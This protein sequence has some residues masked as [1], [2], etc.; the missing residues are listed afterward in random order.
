[1]SKKNNTTFNTNND[2]KMPFDI[3]RQ[4]A[5]VFGGDDP[6]RIADNVNLY[7]YVFENFTKQRDEFVKNLDI[8]I[9]V[10]S[11]GRLLRFVFGNS[12]LGVNIS[13]PIEKIDVKD[14]EAFLFSKYSFWDYISSAVLVD[15]YACVESDVAVDQFL[16]T[17]DSWNRYVAQVGY[18]ERQ[19]LNFNDTEIKSALVQDNVVWYYGS[20][21]SGKTYMG[22]RELKAINT[23]KITYNP[24][25]SSEYE[26][27]IVRIMLCYGRNIAFLLDDLQCDMER[28]LEI[29]LL[30]SKLKDSFKER[31][32]H[33]FLITWASLKNDERFISYQSL[34]NA[35]ESNSKRYITQLMKPIADN[36]LKKVCGNNLALLNIAGTIFAKGKLDNP[37]EALFRTFVKTNDTELLFRIYKL[38]VLGTYEYLVQVNSTDPVIS[39]NE[40]NTIKTINGKYYVGHKEICRFIANYIMSNTEKLGLSVLPSRDKIIYEYIQG[41]ESTNQWKAI[42]QLI[43]E[44]EEVVLQNVSPI[45]RGLHCFEQEIALQTYK[46][47]T[48]GNTPSSMYFVLKVA[49]L[50]G[51][52]SE[53][54]EVLKNFCSKFEVRDSSIE[55]K[56]DE[57]ATTNDFEQIKKRMINEDAQIIVDSFERG[58]DFESQRAHKNW[59]LG[60]VVGLKEELFEFGYEEL[61]SAA[62]SELFREQDAAG[63]WYPKRVPWISARVLIGLTQAGY[64]IIDEHVQKGVDYLLSILDYNDYWDAHTGGWNNPFETS[65]L[66]LEAI[67]NA[68][69]CIEYETKTKIDKVINYLLESKDEWMSKDKIVD[70]TATAC[71]LLKYYDYSQDLVDFIQRLCED[72]VYNLVSKN[73]ELN[74]EEKQSCETTQIAWYVMDFC[75][76]VLYTH[77]PDLLNQFVTRSLQGQV[78]IGGGYMVKPQKIF[79][80]YSEDSKGTVKRIQKI[81]AYLRNKG[82][83]VWCYPDEPLGSN[84]VTFMQRAPEADLILVMGSKSYKEKSL[85]IDPYK[86][87][88]GVFFENLVLAQLFIQNN[89]DKIIPIAFERETSFSESFPPPFDSNKGLVCK[90][91]TNS[92]LSNLAKEIEFKVGGT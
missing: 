5:F 22:I 13:I 21:C 58:S 38:C 25:F 1:M 80:S 40:L 82:H 33:V 53:Y 76:D 62:V 31:N 60:L 4:I 81:S 89:M 83:I 77:L 27:D 63:Y 44:Q 45:W 34:F 6:N 67:F 7:N 65:S 42:K 14:F 47:P 55:V 88:S 90:R 52:I 68:K 56:F 73:A 36:N 10:D 75:W 72:R 16:D 46:D 41:L 37:G 57:I 87:G 17:L 74:L 9:D 3:I 30:L 84:I 59:L 70:G 78:T 92:F 24:C 15:E 43:G 2:Y 11:K 50:L 28:A 51:V 48:W 39:Q 23:Q 29:F 61:Y 35:I 32:V 26:Y 49:S 85:L 12:P 91:V 86:K 54:K 19:L 18:E 8:S 71:C 69:T 79:I 64:S 20:S 66:C